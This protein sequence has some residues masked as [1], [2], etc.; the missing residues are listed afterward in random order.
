M[1]FL[2]ALRSFVFGDFPVGR[3]AEPHRCLLLGQDDAPAKGNLDQP[4]EL[5][6]EP[7][8]LYKQLL[9]RRVNSSART[10]KKPTTDFE[11]SK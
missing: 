10:P 11:R 4:G 6:I 2:V 8:G 1:I 5:T 7:P 3:L 9:Q